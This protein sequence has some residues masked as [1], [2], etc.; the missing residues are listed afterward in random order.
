M[1][2]PEVPAQDD[3]GANIEDRTGDPVEGSLQID[4]TDWADDS[5]ADEDQEE[6]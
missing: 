5:E 6:D 3:D 4:T 1:T 2:T